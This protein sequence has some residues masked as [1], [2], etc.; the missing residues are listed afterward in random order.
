M[1]SALNDGDFRL[2]LTRFRKD[3]L[4]FHFIT[5]NQSDMLEDTRYLK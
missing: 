4:K 3:F 1:L 5:I 2:R